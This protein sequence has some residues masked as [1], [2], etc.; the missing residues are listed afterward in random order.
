MRADPERKSPPPV[1][2]DGPVSCTLRRPQSFTKQDADA[3]AGGPDR[4]TAGASG[5][6]RIAG[7]LR[8]WGRP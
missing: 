3:Q 4:F 1:D 5:R 8:L 6:Q 2:G 7:K